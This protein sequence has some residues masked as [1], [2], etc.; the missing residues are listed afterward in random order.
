MVWL[1]V[2]TVEPC[3]LDTTSQ[4]LVDHQPP[5]SG[6]DEEQR[7]RHRDNPAT[8]FH[9][10]YGCAKPLEMYSHEFK[11]PECTHWVMDDSCWTLEENSW[12]VMD[13]DR[14]S[15]TGQSGTELECL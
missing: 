8:G 3:C 15:V 10:F 9:L 4:P 11:V 12:F 5:A 7:Q 2:H 1:Q 14:A 13:T 6:L